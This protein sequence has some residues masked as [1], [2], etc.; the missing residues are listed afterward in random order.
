MSAIIQRSKLNISRVKNVCISVSRAAES[1]AAEGH[2]LI[3]YYK[4]FI[5]YVRYDIGTIRM[6]SQKRFHS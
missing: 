3:L 4:E 5:S 2:E 1:H 6:Y